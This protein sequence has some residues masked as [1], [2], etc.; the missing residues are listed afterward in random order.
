MTEPP[1]PWWEPVVVVV[2][3]LGFTLLTVWA[4]V[5]GGAE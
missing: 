4:L 3:A 5:M 2:C 1:V